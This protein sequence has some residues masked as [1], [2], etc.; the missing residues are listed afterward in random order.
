MATRTILAAKA[1]LV[2]SVSVLFA[3][4]Q[5]SAQTQSYHRKFHAIEGVNKIDSTHA[6]NMQVSV[7]QPDKSIMKFRVAVLNPSGKSL[8]VVIRKG[9]DVLFFESAPGEQ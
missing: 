6:A 5:A 8:N 1:A 7:S 3:T 9:Y 4:S 2:L